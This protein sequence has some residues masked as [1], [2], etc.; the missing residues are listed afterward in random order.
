MAG[1]AQSVGLGAGFE[2]VG[3]EGDAVDDGGGE[4]GVGDDFAPLAEREVRGDGHAGFLFA[5]GEDL[6]Q[7]FG[8]AGVELDVAEFVEASESLGA[9]NRRVL[10]AEILPN[11]IAPIIVV[12]FLLGGLLILA[13]GSAVAPFIYTLF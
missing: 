1:D 12:M 5:F 11:L 3:V 9:S 8:S 10:F 4:A 6:E 7:Q 2:D 13:K